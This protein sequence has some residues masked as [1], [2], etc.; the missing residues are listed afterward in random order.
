MNRC[1]SCGKQTTRKGLWGVYICKSCK[2]KYK[3]AQILALKELID[4]HR[5]EFESIL[6]KKIIEQFEVK[7]GNRKNK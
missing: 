5:D 3:E 1:E 4:L 6:D 7:N 2:N